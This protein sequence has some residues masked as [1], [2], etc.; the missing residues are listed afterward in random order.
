[1]RN[2]DNM[3]HAD[4]IVKNT[5]YCVFSNLQPLDIVNHAA[6]PVHI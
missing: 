1:L 4:V 5:L 2:G 6:I 3:C